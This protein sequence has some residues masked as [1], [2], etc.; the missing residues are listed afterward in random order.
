[1]LPIIPFQQ[2]D[3]MSSLWLFLCP[4]VVCLV[5]MNMWTYVNASLVITTWTKTEKSNKY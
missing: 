1:M 4:M 5:Y 2:L 3:I